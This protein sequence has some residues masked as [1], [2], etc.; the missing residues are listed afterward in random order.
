MKFVSFG[1]WSV[2]ADRIVAVHIWAEQKC[3]TVHCGTEE[4]YRQYY[5]TQQDTREVYE[6]LLEELSKIEA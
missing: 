3:I 1:N 2:K 5:K 4:K 6:K